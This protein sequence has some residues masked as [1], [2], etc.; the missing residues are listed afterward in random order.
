M[1]LYR[2]AAYQTG[3]RVTIDYLNEYAYDGNDA[4]INQPSLFSLEQSK[5]EWPEWY[6][7]RIVR[8]EAPGRW[9]V[10]RD[11]YDWWKRQISEKTT[12]GHRYFCMMCLAVYARKCDIEEDELRSDAA[13]FQEQFNEMGNDTKEPFTWEETE[14]A[15]EAYNESYVTFPRETIER[16]SGVAM[17]A[18][19]RNGRTRLEHVTRLNRIFDLEKE[20][21][22][23]EKRGRPKGSIKFET[24]KGSQIKEYKLA[25]PELSNRQIATE[26]GVSRN[27]VNKWLKM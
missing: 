14:K 11:L 20:L 1:H 3:G 16:I 24:L 13:K 21:G 6:E 22:E 10:K 25:H 2:L 15:L 9:H 8:G 23:K 27:T 17:P 18:N 19:K 12:I 4:V 26:L 7:S 5:E